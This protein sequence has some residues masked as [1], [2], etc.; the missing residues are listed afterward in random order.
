M[1]EDAQQQKHHQNHVCQREDI[2]SKCMCRPG[3]VIFATWSL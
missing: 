3:I 1:H 2:L